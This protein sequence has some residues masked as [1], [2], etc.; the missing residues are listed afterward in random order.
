V[1]LIATCTAA[2]VRAAPVDSVPGIAAEVEQTIVDVDKAS[3]LLDD[4]YHA[5]QNLERLSLHVNE[6]GPGLNHGKDFSRLKK[7]EVK[8]D[9]GADK[10]LD[11]EK[12]ILE[13]AK[14]VTMDA[15]IFGRKHR[16]LRNQQAASLLRA[17][18]QISIDAQKR[19]HQMTVD[20][21]TKE[22]HLAEDVKAFMTSKIPAGQRHN[23]QAI[24][25]AEWAKLNSEARAK[26]MEVTLHQIAQVESDAVEKEKVPQRKSKQVI[27]KHPYM[28]TPIHKP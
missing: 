3:P 15:E 4:A 26:A 12:H 17:S 2:S 6:L 19:V 8:L 14:H 21:K 7:L 11:A 1:A 20:L 22:Q 24:R 25:Q 27:R 16:S 28:S 13:D 10:A 5:V 23:W 9:L 18:G